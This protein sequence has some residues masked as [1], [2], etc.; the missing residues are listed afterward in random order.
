MTSVGGLNNRMGFGVIADMSLRRRKF[1]M[2]C[3]S[4]ERSAVL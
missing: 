2:T 3:T 4:S 1:Q